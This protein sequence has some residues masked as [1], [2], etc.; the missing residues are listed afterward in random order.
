M[1]SFFVSLEW[2][3]DWSIWP[4]WKPS[5]VAKYKYAKKGVIFSRFAQFEVYNWVVVVAA[6]AIGFKRSLAKIVP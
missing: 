3:R 4:L 5:V 2:N 1:N 6:G